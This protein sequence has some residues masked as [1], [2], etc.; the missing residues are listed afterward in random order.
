MPVE[1]YQFDLDDNKNIRLTDLSTM[2]PVAAYDTIR[3]LNFLTGFQD[4]RFES[5]LESL[6]EKTFIDSVLSTTPKII[7]TL[8]DRQGRVN[9]VKIYKKKGYAGSYTG[10]KATFEPLDLDRGYALVNDGEEF[11]LIQYFVFDRITRNLGY[12]IR[13]Q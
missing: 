1:S 13:R 8:T 4:V 12:F 7:I 10:E 11:V 9:S 3:A 2:Q 6:L 5:L